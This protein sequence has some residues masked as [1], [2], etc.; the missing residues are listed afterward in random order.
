LALRFDHFNPRPI[1][2]P[3]RGSRVGGRID[4][5]LEE[6]KDGLLVESIA[7][8]GAAVE[9]LALFQGEDDFYNSSHGFSGVSN[10]DG[11]PIEIRLP[12]PHAH[13]DSSVRA[14][15]PTEPP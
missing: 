8:L 3:G 4:H 13:N 12:R 10:A 11:F 5:P 1:H 2:S 7:T 6:R 9:F 15:E 14:H